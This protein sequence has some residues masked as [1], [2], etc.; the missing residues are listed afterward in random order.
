MGNG[1]W[2]L[3]A[4]LMVAGGKLGGGLS[5]GGLPA[6]AGPPEAAALEPRPAP[7]AAAA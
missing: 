7:V 4:A 3:L 1:A 2:K 5:T 6:R